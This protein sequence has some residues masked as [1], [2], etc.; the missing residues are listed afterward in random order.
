LISSAIDP[1]KIEKIKRRIDGIA[2]PPY[3]R[4]LEK[5]DDLLI[6]LK[7]FE[8]YNSWTWLK[9][10]SK[11]IDAEARLK[12][13]KKA[14]AYARKYGSGITDLLLPQAFIICHANDSTRF[15]VKITKFREQVRSMAKMSLKEIC[16]NRTYV[17]KMAAVSFFG[18]TQLVLHKRKYDLLDGIK[19]ESRTRRLL[20]TLK[21][22]NVFSGINPKT[23]KTEIFIDADFFIYVRE[24]N[25]ALLRALPHLFLWLKIF[26]FY[27]SIIFLHAI[28][29][30]LFLNIR[31]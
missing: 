12:R 18:L 19:R 26:V 22:R 8:F 29:K 14:V 9:N 2:L 25:F 15:I 27:R 4:V 3:D 30:Y 17:K 10:P 24:S 16:T 23:G 20:G 6:I 7:P 13:H 1:K 5:D 28:N 21:P 11:F 31:K